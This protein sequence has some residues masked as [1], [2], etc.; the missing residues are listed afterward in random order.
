MLDFENTRGPETS[1]LGPNPFNSHSAS[2]AAAGASH[3]S[4]HGQPF[5]RQHPHTSPAL[6]HWLTLSLDHVGRG[7]LLVGAG[8]QLLHANRLARQALAGGTPALLLDVQ[9]RLCAPNPRDNKLLTEAIEAALNKGLRRLLTLG[10]GAV[11]GASAA[12]SASGPCEN[13]PTTVAVLPIAAGTAGP[14]SDLASPSGN[15]ALIS[16]QQSSR[17]KDLAVQIFA[18]EHGCTSAETAVLEALLAGHTPEAIAQ[19]KQVRLCTVRTQ[20][21]Q[22]RLKT[23][24]HTIRELLDRVAALPPMMVVV[25]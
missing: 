25:Q 10:R 5:T 4:L 23:G 6:A 21:G 12:P 1:A 13:A 17:S 18:R 20:I 15:V 8:G 7:M 19:H 3:H 24:S 11:A 22:L 2:A 14:A 16:L 9:G